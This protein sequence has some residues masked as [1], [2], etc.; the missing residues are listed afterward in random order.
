[1][2]R[3]VVA[4]LLCAV[5]LSGCAGRSAESGDTTSRTQALW[6]S[7]T[8]Y[9]GDSS[10][11]VALVRQI[12]PGPEGTYSVALQTATPPYALT[13]DFHRV[14][15][16]FPDTNFAEPA[17]LLLG[18]VDNLEKVRFTHDGQEY[19]LTAAQA[20]TSLGYDVKELGR[21]QRTLTSFIDRS[22]D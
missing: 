12:G 6:S 10:G 13:L 8:T 17:T 21:N 16:P 15:K 2:G 9:V 4:A 18:L 22:H 5:V 20:S 14:D 11:V 7:R 19:S 1:M 3:G